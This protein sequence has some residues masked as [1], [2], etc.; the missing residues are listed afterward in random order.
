MT[1]RQGRGGAGE[2]PGGLALVK[3][4]DFETRTARVWSLLNGRAEV[5][6]L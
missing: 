5:R 4:G 6:Q 1:L 2:P 3:H